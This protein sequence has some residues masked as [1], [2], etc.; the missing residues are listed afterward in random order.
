MPTGEV[1]VVAG[2]DDHVLSPAEILCRFRSTTGA[3]STRRLRL[4]YRYLDLRRPRMAAICV[5]GR[6]RSGQCVGRLDDLGFLEVETPTLIRSTP[7]VPAT[8]W[9][10]VR[11]RQGHSFYALP[12]SPQLFKQLL[13]VAGVERYY[14]VARCYRDEDFRSDRQLEFTQLDLRGSFWGQDDVLD[15]L[16]QPSRARSSRTFQRATVADGRSR[17]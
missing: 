5:P 11:L 10:R 15:T 6:R 4:Q 8:C 3:R 13:M 7:R 12:Q 17:A 2:S 9:S 1:E 16:E 14:Q